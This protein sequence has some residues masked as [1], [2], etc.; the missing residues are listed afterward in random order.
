[1][2]GRR[3]YLSTAQISQVIDETIWK[4]KIAHERKAKEY[5]DNIYRSDVMKDV[6]P[7]I[8]PVVDKPLKPISYFDTKV[9]LIS[10][11]E[12]GARQHTPQ[13]HRLESS[14]G[15][16]LQKSDLLCSD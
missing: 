7:Q 5:W 11:R 3:Q 1:M 9:R 10:S 8:V 16:R 4:E 13:I 2:S 12:I 6:L 14:H 15:H